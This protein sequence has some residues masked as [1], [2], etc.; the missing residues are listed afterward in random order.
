MAKLLKGSPP[1]NVDDFLQS[2]LRHHAEKTLLHRRWVMMKTR[3][4]RCS[5]TPIGLYVAPC[6]LLAS[7]KQFKWIRAQNPRRRKLSSAQLRHHRVTFY[8]TC[9]MSEL[10]E[11]GSSNCIRNNFPKSGSMY[12]SKTCNQYFRWWGSFPV[13]EGYNFDPALPGRVG[14][15]EMSCMW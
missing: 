11:V 13:R 3:S 8:A 6:V 2:N 12:R 10:S 7:R 1:P 4:Y 14:L 5:E 15:G 9:T